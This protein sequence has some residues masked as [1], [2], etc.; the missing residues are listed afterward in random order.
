MLTMKGR[1]AY[2]QF[3]EGNTDDDNK[4]GR[5]ANNSESTMYKQALT[6]VF[7]WKEV[8]NT[9]RSMLVYEKTRGHSW[10]SRDTKY[11]SD[12]IALRFI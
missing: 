4:N 6:D 10:Y 8:A 11:I 12:T 7:W 1:H 3:K 9:S 5:A 2:V